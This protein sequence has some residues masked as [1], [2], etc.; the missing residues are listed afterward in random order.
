LDRVGED[1]ELEARSGLASALHGEVELVG[2]LAR[3][4]RGHRAD[5]PVGGID[6]NERRRRVVRPAE[7]A[8]DRTLGRSLA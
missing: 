1:E 6:R 5:R 4:E 2:R 7:R 3:H 8:L